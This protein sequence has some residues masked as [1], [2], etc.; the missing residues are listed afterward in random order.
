MRQRNSRLGC[1]WAAV[2]ASSSVTSTAASHGTVSVTGLF[3]FR[4]F[5]WSD[6]N[7]TAVDGQGFAV[8]EGIGDLLVGFGNDATERLARDVHALSC[9]L[10]V[11]PFQIGQ[12]DGLQF[13]DRQRHLFERS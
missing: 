10:L 4:C 8:D 5:C 9:L 13:I 2:T 6:F 11:E 7:G 12:A 1:R 3:R